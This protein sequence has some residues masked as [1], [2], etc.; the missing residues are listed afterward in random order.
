MLDRVDDML[1]PVARGLFGKLAWSEMKENARGA[2]NAGHAADIV[3]RQLAQLAKKM[4][5]LEIHLVG[6]SAGAIFI[7]PMLA[8]L[9][10]RGLQAGTCTLWAPAC[11]HADFEADYAPALEAGTLG[12]LALFMLGDQT[13]QNDNCAHIYNKSL[14]YLVS[15]AF[16][17]NARIPGS[18]QKEH[19]GVPLL[20]MAKFIDADHQDY[21]APFHQRLQALGV[22]IVIAPNDRPEGDAGASKA[23]HHGDFDNDMRTVLATLARVIGPATKFD[24]GA[25]RDPMSGERTTRVKVV[26]PTMRERADEVTVKLGPSLAAA[27]QRRATLDRLTRPQDD[28][29]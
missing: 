7:A 9:K 14:L 8:L 18:K 6:H 11:T 28:G 20:G 16:E 12:K 21:L 17:K 29:R 2:S 24:A 4:P 5:G 13:E 3:V 19:R 23:E 10:K 1:E 22:D 15:H 27:K 26:N 25:V